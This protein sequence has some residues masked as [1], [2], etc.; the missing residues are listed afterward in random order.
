MFFLLFSF[1]I[2]LLSPLSK[3]CVMLV[4]NWPLCI[5]FFLIP[6]V[7]KLLLDFFPQNTFFKQVL[8]AGKWLDSSHLGMHLFEDVF[9]LKLDKY[10]QWRCRS[11]TVLDANAEVAQFSLMLG[12]RFRRLEVRALQSRQL[13]GWNV[14]SAELGWIVLGALK[15]KTQASLRTNESRYYGMCSKER[16]NQWTMLNKVLFLYC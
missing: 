14:A 15:Q 5:Q 9:P 13:K 4:L 6:T 11:V 16:A 10:L 1:Q 8:C 3:F 12:V 7:T 2:P